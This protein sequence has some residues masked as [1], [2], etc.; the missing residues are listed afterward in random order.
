MHSVAQTEETVT[1][2]VPHHVQV[3]LNRTAEELG[4]DLRL[5][6]A[7]ML[8]QLGKLSAGAA[9]ELA[10]VPKVIF[11]DLCAQY[12]LPIS[13]ITPDELTAEVG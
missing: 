11:L 10:G 5:Y 13:Q 2:R 8:F 9:A 3:M 12:N 1:L 7:L 4:R 6:S